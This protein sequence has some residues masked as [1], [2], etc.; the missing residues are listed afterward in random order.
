MV[1]AFR[2]CVMC[3]LFLFLFSSLAEAQDINRAVVTGDNVNIRSGP[4][5]KSKVFHQSSSGTVFLVDSVAIR[6]ES[7]NSEWYKI[8]FSI[9]MMDGNIFGF[10]QAHRESIYEFS[11]PY[12]SARFVKK[13]AITEDERWELDALARGRPV[14]VHVGDDFSGWETESRVLKAPVVLYKEPGGADTF[15]LPAGTTVLFGVDSEGRLGYHFDKD[16]KYWYYVI[17]ENKKLIGWA[18]NEVIQ[19]IFSSTP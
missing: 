9:N 16:D 19:N 13:E 2:K 8:L 10:Y 3:L 11:H 1:K 7:D 12:I 14:E 5:A 18:T 15:T 4:S 17:D 6:D